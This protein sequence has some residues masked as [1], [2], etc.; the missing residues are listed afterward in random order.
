LIVAVSGFLDEEP[1]LAFAVSDP[2]RS[3]APRSFGIKSA[4]TAAPVVIS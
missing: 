4:G 2:F 3:T 1:E